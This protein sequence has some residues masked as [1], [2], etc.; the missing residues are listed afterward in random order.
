MVSFPTHSWCLLVRTDF[1]D[2]DAWAQVL[3]EVT[4]PSPE[5]FLA[6]VTAFD[7]RSAD[8]AAWESLRD[9]AM[10]TPD[11]EYS[12]V[13]FVVDSLTISSADHPILAVSTS[14]FHRDSLPEEFEAMRPFR[15]VP[16]ELWAVENNL[17]LANLDWRDFAGRVDGEGVFRG[18]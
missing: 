4:R 17:N 9:S 10:A 7:D 8:G 15:C 3:E 2:D 18:F 1:T 16:S 11:D 6:N 5:G 14:R 13:L 12:S